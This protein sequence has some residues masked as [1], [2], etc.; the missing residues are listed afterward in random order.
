MKQFNL[1]HKVSVQLNENGK[2]IWDEYVATAL[3]TL[4]PEVKEQVKEH[5]LNKVNENNILTTEF[6]QIMNV[7]GSHIHTCPF[8]FNVLIDETQL[9][10]YEQGKTL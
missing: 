8:D 2:Q 3:E 7:F 10:D 5:Y 1:N 6:W 9:V 4:N